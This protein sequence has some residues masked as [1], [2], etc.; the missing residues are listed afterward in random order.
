MQPCSGRVWL[1]CERMMPITARLL[2]GDSIRF[3]IFLLILFRCA[4]RVRA[5]LLPSNYSH[6]TAF[7]QY[8][9]TITVH[10]VLYPG[11]IGIS[12]SF[13]RRNI[14]RIPGLYPATLPRHVYGR[15]AYSTSSPDTPWR[16]TDSRR[17]PTKHKRHT[18]CAHVARVTAVAPNAPLLVRVSIDMV[19]VSAAAVTAARAHACTYITR[20]IGSRAQAKHIIVWYACIITPTAAVLDTG[21]HAAARSHV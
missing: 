19:M 5:T 1:V 2:S 21:T 16:R 14:C 3:R 20:T 8:A 12:E 13:P 6:L 10:A 15:T 17:V 4:I 18:L 9:Q 7:L 11:E